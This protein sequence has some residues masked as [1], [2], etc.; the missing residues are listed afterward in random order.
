M[1]KSPNDVLVKY[2]LSKSRELLREI[3]IHIEHELWHTAINR[4][5]YACYY[6]ISALLL[7]KNIKPHTHAGVRQMLGLHII[8]QGLISEDL[9][10]FY[11]DLSDKRQTSDYDDFVQITKDDVYDMYPIAKEL[12]TQIDKLLND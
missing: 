5:Y 8:K 7:S 3:E 1:N 9:G 10:K 11:S 12:I 2:R 4:L 6:A